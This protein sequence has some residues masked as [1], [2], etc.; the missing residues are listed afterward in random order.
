YR[1]LE[2]LMETL[3]DLLDSCELN[4][5]SIRIIPD[6]SNECDATN[7]PIEQKQAVYSMNYTNS[8]MLSV[9]AEHTGKTRE[10]VASFLADTF[11]ANQLT[12]TEDELNQFMRQFVE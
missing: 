8:I 11:Q 12:V 5:N 7:L 3:S 10:A 6:G 4:L 9:L 1:A 2:E